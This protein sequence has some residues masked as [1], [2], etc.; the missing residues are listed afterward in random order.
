M[1]KEQ[2]GGRAKS[3]AQ[4][5]QEYIAHPYIPLHCSSRARLIVGGVRVD[6]N[7]EKLT[8]PGPPL[9]FCVVSSKSEQILAE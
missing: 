6:C 7:E 2:N 4:W 8:F 9:C 1:N 3:I 5:L